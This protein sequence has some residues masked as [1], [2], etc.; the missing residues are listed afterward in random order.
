VGK[1]GA[2]GI[3]INTLHGKTNNFSF[4]DMIEKPLESRD[5]DL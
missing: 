5:A 1:E 2:R 4:L 3:D